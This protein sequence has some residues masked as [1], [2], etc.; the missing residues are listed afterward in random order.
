[1]NGQT[2]AEELVALCKA[3]YKEVTGKEPVEPQDRGLQ[4]GE[5]IENAEG[6]QTNK[7]LFAL[8][9]DSQ[10]LLMIALEDESCGLLQLQLGPY[11]S[12][13]IGSSKEPLSDEVKE[14][15]KAKIVPVLRNAGLAKDTLG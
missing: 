9:R 10:K 14:G 13:L 4:P 11:R 5:R 6:L 7:I 12:V 1:M 3:T 8:V 2:S 15:L